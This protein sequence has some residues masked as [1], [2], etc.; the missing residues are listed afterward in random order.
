[1]LGLGI[2]LGDLIL[3]AR[4]D[5]EAGK[6]EASVVVETAPPDDIVLRVANVGRRPF[7]VERAVYSRDL[8]GGA[9]FEPDT[10]RGLFARDPL[11]PR[12]LEPDDPALELIVPAHVLR[13]HFGTEPPAWAWTED[14]YGRVARHEISEDVRRAIRQTKRRRRVRTPS[15]DLTEV[16]IGDSAPVNHEW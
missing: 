6:V 13:L 10:R 7:T 9:E 16:E 2:A 8:F 5:R 11:L 3:T 12:R 1:V 15:G 4:R 14:T